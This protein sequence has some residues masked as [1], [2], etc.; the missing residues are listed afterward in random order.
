LYWVATENNI[1]AILNTIF[2][3]LIALVIFAIAARWGWRLMRERRAIA[4]LGRESAEP[5]VVVVMRRV[6]DSVTSDEG[7]RVLLQDIRQR[8]LQLDP[9]VADFLEFL[10]ERIEGRPGTHSRQDWADWWSGSP[11]RARQRLSSDCVDELGRLLE[12]VRRGAAFY[13]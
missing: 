10:S 5:D 3:N 9:G 7:F 6:L 11:T 1:V 12:D 13:G 4:A 8:Q 2:R